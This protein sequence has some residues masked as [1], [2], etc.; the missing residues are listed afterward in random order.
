MPVCYTARDRTLDAK[1]AGTMVLRPLRDLYRGDTFCG[2]V[3]D[4]DSTSNR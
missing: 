2:E 3:E 4:D 1:V